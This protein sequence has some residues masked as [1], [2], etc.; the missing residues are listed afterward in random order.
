MLNLSFTAEGEGGEV[1][2]RRDRE[3]DEVAGIMIWRM[4]LTEG[5]GTRNPPLSSSFLFEPSSSSI[6][7]LTYIVR[8]THKCEERSE[9]K[10]RRNWRK[11]DWGGQVQR[12]QSRNTQNIQSLSTIAMAS[13][14]T[15]EMATLPESSSTP[16]PL[17][18][19]DDGDVNLLVSVFSAIG[20]EV[21]IIVGVGLIRV[22]LEFL[23]MAVAFPKI[24]N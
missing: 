12:R 6:N 21:V 18:G 20:V 22:E 8:S 9:L 11:E 4:N 17:F 14:D 1:R 2:Q 15:L 7:A 3:D 24:Y 5:D 10:D 16:L 13:H 23:M 19:V